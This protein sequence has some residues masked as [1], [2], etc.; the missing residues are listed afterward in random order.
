MEARS[1]QILIKKNTRE[2]FKTHW[3]RYESISY[4]V[5]TV[6]VTLLIWEL[7]TKLFN[8][9]E[10]ILP[11]PSL[12]FMK[13]IEESNI[14]WNHSL[15]T[16]FEVVFGFLLSVVVGIAI[17]VLIF[18][19]KTFERS[20]YPLLVTSQSIPKVAIAPLFIIWMGFGV[21]SKVLIAFLTA[22][23]PIVV[24]TVSGLRVTKK[25]MYYLIYTM[26]GTKLQLFSKV[27]FPNALPSIFSGLKIAVAMSVVGAIV[28]EFVASDKGLGY[29]LMV[30][31]GQMN[32]VLVFAIIL[33]LSFIGIVMF[34]SIEILEKI[35]LAKHK[36]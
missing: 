19:S 11:S 20:V 3:K 13:I 10:Y 22:F 14:L 36:T 18:S 34:Y 23:F 2:K 21:S 16:L 32:T 12:I 31:N 33:V 6:V 26:G 24:A 8:I 35:V 5:I 7:I 4:P 17:A 1:E 29:L 9:A 28:G 30:A 25:E 27:I 15:V